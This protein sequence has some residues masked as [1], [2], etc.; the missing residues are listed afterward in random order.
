MLLIF[1]RE[2]SASRVL[3]LAPNEVAHRL[4]LGLL[5]C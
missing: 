4:V 1:D 5:G 2:I 3:V